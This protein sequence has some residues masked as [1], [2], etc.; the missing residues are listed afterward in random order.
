[1]KI[2]MQNAPYSPMVALPC[3]AGTEYKAGQALNLTAGAATICTGD[4]KPA[5]ICHSTKKGVVGENIEAVKITD[6][7]VFEAALQTAAS[8]LKAGSKV[9]LHTDGILVLPSETGVLVVESLPEGTGAGAKVL[10]R[11]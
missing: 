5:Y 8:S 9:K 3:G 1:M 6:D 7:M 2:H 11:I 4:V 10:V